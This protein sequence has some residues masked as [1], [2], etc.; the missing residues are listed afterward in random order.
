[1]SP[2]VDL[3]AASP[4]SYIS[5]GRTRNF[6]TFYLKP[7]LI[8][9]TCIRVRHVAVLIVTGSLFLALYIVQQ[10]P[11][12][13][14][15]FTITPFSFTAGQDDRRPSV[16][17]TLDLLPP[18]LCNVSPTPFFY[19]QNSSNLYLA[20]TPDDPVADTVIRRIT[21]HEAVSNECLEHW[22]ETGTWS[23]A[24]LNLKLEEPRVDLV[25]TWVNGSDPLHRAARKANVPAKFSV[26]Q[27]TSA[28]MLERQYRQ[29]DELRYSL[30]SAKSATS[31]WKGSRFHLVA[32]SY[33]MPLSQSRD[34][35]AIDGD[36]EEEREGLRLGQVPQ[37]LD[38]T[39][40]GERVPKLVVHYDANIFRL[41]PPSPNNVISD[42]E[43]SDW[44]AS[45]L[46]T[47]NSMAIESQLGNL[48]PSEVADNTV[49]LMDDTYLL[50]P[51]PTSS[52]YSAIHGPIFHLQP[53]LLVKPTGPTLPSGWSE[54]RGLQTA[55]AHLSERFGSRGRPYLVHNARSIPLPLLH[56]ASM[57]FPS[58]LASTATS[59][60]R[61]MDDK[62]PETHTLWLATQFIVERHREAL[63]WS[64]VIG[65]WGGQ[66]G[67]ISRGEKVNMWAELGGERGEDKKIVVWPRRDTRLHVKEQ[68]ENAGLPDPGPTNYAFL[69]SDGYPYTYLPLTRYYP[70]PPNENG[71]A[72]LAEP[73]AGNQAPVAC[74]INRIHCFNDNAE[75]EPAVEMFKRIMLDKPS[76]GDCIISALVASSGSNGLSAFLPPRELSD[77]TPPLLTTNHLP[78]SLS[79]ILSFPFPSDPYHFSLR[80]IQRYSYVLGGT[81]SI[82]FGATSADNAK[83]HLTEVDRNNDTA[84]LCIND[85][86]VSIDP[87]AVGLLDEVLKTWMN[88]R[89]PD[90]LE[91]ESVGEY[92]REKHRQEE[93]CL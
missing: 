18:L 66:K 58:A 67:L 59:R 6:L 42:S 15:A 36:E 53:D 10:L 75:F 71:W 22:V 12:T 11:L 5:S 84:L 64:W 47:F 21:A 9:T 79:S 63:L 27:Q 78:V 56:E 43:V 29:H 1:M 61:G 23:E 90:R 7:R 50:R 87:K 77:S 44:R 30:R 34:F 80:L 74:T 39:K 2:P 26:I 82:F 3:E 86:L 49:F 48:P 72:N 52:F 55:A 91:I 4:V 41:L 83:A 13:L 54:W 17:E 19:P 38:L 88:S 45:S 70:R 37:W 31:S 14:D 89:W 51:L 46:P 60:F 76:C 25:W 32:N 92:R 24:C 8:V 65:K 93:F 85:D 57:T 35:D 16:L 28:V 62:N 81:P 69:S 40:T 68:M 73:L 20:F 33:Y